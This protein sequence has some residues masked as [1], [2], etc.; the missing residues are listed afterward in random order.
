M[1]KVAVIL[2]FQKTTNILE[3][4][5][6]RIDFNRFFAMGTFSKS[7]EMLIARECNFKLELIN[8]Y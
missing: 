7:I 4:A 1:F 6:I 3:G 5:F 8:T 2:L